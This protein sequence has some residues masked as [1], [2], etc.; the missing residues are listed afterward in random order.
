MIIVFLIYIVGFM[1]SLWL[2]HNFKDEL[3]INH[4]D[5]PH[6]EYYDDYDDNSSAYISFSTMWPIFWLFKL[7]GLM[8]KL[9]YKLS[10]KFEK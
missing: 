3:D 2:M 9:L 6:D 4:Y 7:V 1:L 8:W 5:P 10:K